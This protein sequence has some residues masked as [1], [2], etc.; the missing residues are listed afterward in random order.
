MIKTYITIYYNIFYTIKMQNH[1]IVGSKPL[2]IRIK[3]TRWNATAG[4]TKI[5]IMISWK[6]AL[7][8]CDT[9]KPSVQIE[10]NTGVHVAS[11]RK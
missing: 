5:N 2:Q 3:Q 9:E 1:K 6:V 4:H 10:S 11:F 8:K 7:L